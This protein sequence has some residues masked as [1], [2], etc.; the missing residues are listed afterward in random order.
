MFATYDRFHCRPRCKLPA[1][2]SARFPETGRKATTGGSTTT[3]RSRRLAAV[4]FADIAGYTDLSSRDEEAALK[5]VDE[6][7]RLSK[8]SVE[9]HGGRIV[10]YVGDAVLTVFD[11]AD[12][13]VRSA[14]A[15][16]EGF[17]SL[18]IEDCGLR[19]GVHL[20]EVVEA[21]AKL[22]GLHILTLKH[23]HRHDH[24]RADTSH[25]PTPLQHVGDGG[26]K[27]EERDDAS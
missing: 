9:S 17:T 10:K 6:L 22:G 25:R 27:D 13:A 15:L 3:E 2:I 18:G 16:Q 26:S 21:E 23:L 1:A 19:V 5:A 7:Q 4:W 20:G 12:A 14:L 24:D 8:D 11:S